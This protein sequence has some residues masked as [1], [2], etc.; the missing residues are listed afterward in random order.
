MSVE[1][2]IHFDRPNLTSVCVEAA[3]IH[4][5]IGQHSSFK[6]PSHP[7]LCITM[8]YS[9]H[10]TCQSV[11]LHLITA[12]PSMTCCLFLKCVYYYCQFFNTVFFCTSSHMTKEA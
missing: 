1:M 4:L 9:A 3:L 10:V 5:A 6:Q 11:C 8:S 7:Y 2:F 12:F